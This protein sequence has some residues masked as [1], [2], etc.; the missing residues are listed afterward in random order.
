DASLT[1]YD[2]YRS[3]AHRRLIFEEFFWL[4][5]ALQLVR[6]ERKKEPKG[7][8]I[9]ITDT[10]KQRMAGILPFRLTDAQRRVIRRI[11]DDMS[12]DKPMNRLLQG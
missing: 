3:P 7:A 6:G 4:S 2:N 8:I 5:F 12:S 1:E 9:E 10:M 11:F